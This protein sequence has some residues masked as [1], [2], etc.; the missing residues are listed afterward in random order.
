MAVQ[1]GQINAVAEPKPQSITGDAL[2]PAPIDTITKLTQT[3]TE[4]AP[5]RKRNPHKRMENP[6]PPDRKSVV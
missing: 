3:P 5:Q 4:P 2:P 6:P 1:N